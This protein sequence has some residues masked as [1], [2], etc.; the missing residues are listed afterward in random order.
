MEVRT[1]GFSQSQVDSAFAALGLMPPDPAELFAIESISGNLVLVD[2]VQSGQ[3]FAFLVAPATPVIAEL[4]EVQTQVAPVVQ[5]F[6]LA[7]GHD[8]SQTTLASI[9]SSDQTAAQLAYDLV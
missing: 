3:E 2:Y 8:P 7:T 5:M 4:P 6:E 9:V 1:M